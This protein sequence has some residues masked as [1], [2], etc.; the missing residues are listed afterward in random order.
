MLEHFEGRTW[1]VNNNCRRRCGGKFECTSRDCEFNF[2]KAVRPSLLWRRV[3]GLIGSNR[4][5]FIKV[6]IQHGWVMALLLGPQTLIGYWPAFEFRADL[7]PVFSFGENDVCVLNPL[8]GMK[9]DHWRSPDIWA[10]AKRERYNCIYASEKVSINIWFHAT[11]V[12][13][14][15]ITQLCV[16]AVK[17]VGAVGLTEVVRQPWTI[18]LSTANCCCQ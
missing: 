1:V 3:S 5:G 12:S 15:W 7:V 13:W 14:A 9:E 17:C 11:T 6:A 10:D 4:L 8:P 18:A 2:K 16:P